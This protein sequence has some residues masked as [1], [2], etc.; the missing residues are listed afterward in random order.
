MVGRFVFF[1][2]PTHIL[3]VFNM[4]VAEGDLVVA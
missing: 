4:I 2:H 1:S 3:D